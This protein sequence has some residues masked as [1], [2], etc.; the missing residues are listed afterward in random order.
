MRHK[1]G[2][3]RWILSRGRVVERDANHQ[4]LR[5]VGSHT[6]ISDRKRIEQERERFL[7]VSSSL[8]VLTGI[9]GYF[10]WVSP[11]FEQI[12]GRAPAEMTSRPWTEFVHP[13]DIN[14]S[15]S[16][17]AN[18][19]AGSETLAFE[20]R[21]QHKDGSYRWLLWRAKLYPEE[22]VIY[23]AA[24][25]ISDRKQ[26]EQ[27]LRASLK[28]KEV[29]LREVYHR[30]KNNMQLV[31]SLLSLQANTIVD[32]A[33]LRLLNES[34]QRVKTMALIHERLY[35]SKNLARINT[36]TYIQDL[37]NNLILSY[38]TTS[39]AIRV[40]LDI[41]ELE[42]DL[43]VAVPC[44]L[45]INELVSNALKY[46]FPDK[47]GE[48]QLR[49]WLDAADNYYLIVKDDG[50]GIPTY[51]NPQNTETLGMQLIYGLTEQLGGAIELDRQVGSQFRITFKKKN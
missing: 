27:E 20:N 4:P 2:S 41:A 1:N 8:Q 51:I 35:R 13:D 5:L 42:L 29:L 31:S 19:F 21:Y 12:L 6:D 18:L 25:E 26:I 14:L 7:A 38:K 34:Q 24:I 48:I 49:F 28:E 33:I 36:A 43:D 44:S 50:I 10:H 17:A 47:Q 22:Q 40:N 3:Y 45:I 37:V 16:E 30:V 46:A 11:S 9:D 23:G 15:T 32:P 39:S